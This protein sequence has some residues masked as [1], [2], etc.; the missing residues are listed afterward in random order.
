[1]IV[2]VGGTTITSPAQLRSLILTKHP[3][4]KLAISYDDPY[5]SSGTVTVTL[6]SGPPQ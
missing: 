3:G 5:G 1:M 6:A 2:S 4:E